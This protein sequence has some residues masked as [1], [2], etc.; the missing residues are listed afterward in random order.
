[1]PNT[2][3]NALQDF[4]LQLVPIFEY[5]YYYIFWSPRQ[6]RTI[7]N[8]W[9][10]PISSAEDRAALSSP[11]CSEREGLSCIELTH[12]SGPTSTLWGHRDYVES[13]SI[14]NLFK[15]VKSAIT[16]EKC[17]SNPSAAP[18]VTWSP[19]HPCHGLPI[20]E[21]GGQREKNGCLLRKAGAK[22][23]FWNFCQPHAGEW[24]QG[25]LKIANLYPMQNLEQMS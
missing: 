24:A 7:T 20:P 6:W 9:W 8:L 3:R 13:L 12:V 4:T 2:Y 10:R 1:M 15:T 21:D 11:G 25:G 5:L 14:C 22:T 17:F 19:L 18:H 23:M 16:F